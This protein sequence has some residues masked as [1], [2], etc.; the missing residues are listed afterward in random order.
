MDITRLVW[1]DHNVQ[2]LAEHGISKGE[3]QSVVALNDW[4][5]Y[6]HEDYPEQVR[7]VGRTAEGRLIAVVL[8]P[9]D[10]PDVWRP[11]TGWEATDDEREYYREEHP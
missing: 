10:E 2:K 9:C 3:V 11:V 6:V 1:A 8:D 7:I 4:E 5:T